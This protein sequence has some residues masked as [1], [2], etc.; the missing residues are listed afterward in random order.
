MDKEDEVTTQIQARFVR[1]W[2][3]TA[4]ALAQNPLAL[5]S[6][7]AAVNQRTG[8]DLDRLLRGL[9]LHYQWHD[10]RCEQVIEARSGK[11]VALPNARPIA[12]QASVSEAKLRSTD[13]RVAYATRHGFRWEALSALFHYLG[14]WRALGT[15]I[16]TTDLDPGG[17]GFP[18]VL[19]LLNGGARATDGSPLDYE[20]LLDPTNDATFNLLRRH[21]M[22]QPQA[23]IVDGARPIRRPSDL[24]TPAL[25]TA[26]IMS[27]FR[28][29]LP[30]APRDE[31]MVACGR[32]LDLRTRNSDRII[33]HHELDRLMD[34]SW[35]ERLYELECPDPLFVLLKLADA[36][37]GPHV[38]CATENDLRKAQVIISLHGG[39][40]EGAGFEARRLIHRFATE[41]VLLPC[42]G[43]MPLLVKTL[44]Q[45]TDAPSEAAGMMAAACVNQ[46][47]DPFRGMPGAPDRSEYVAP[48]PYYRILP[49]DTRSV[50]TRGNVA[51]ALEILLAYRKALGITEPLRV[52][53]VTARPHAARALAEFVDGIP[54]DVA[55]F[56]VHPIQAAQLEGVGEFFRPA[57]WYNLFCEAIKRAYMTG[58]KP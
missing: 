40:C 7:L 57:E 34:T 44:G 20:G 11:C 26:L 10:N 53:I 36:E 19:N 45:G 1:H 39:D 22:Q 32:L 15:H 5:Q 30:E 41:A 13:E 21:L 49:P 47:R 14:F 51:N 42:G 29:M 6:D 56:T 55:T 16:G 58:V 28:D 18:A 50:D 52:V 37:L 24:S 38:G 3:T 54:A 12:I 4:I 31:F 33:L 43:Q 9:K 35:R 23:S 48:L 8:K 27:K 25:V 17:V 2:L 46:F